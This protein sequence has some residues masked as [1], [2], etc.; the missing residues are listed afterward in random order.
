M[1]ALLAVVPRD[2]QTTVTINKI[3]QAYV[4]ILN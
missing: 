1:P 3:S 4:H 2:R